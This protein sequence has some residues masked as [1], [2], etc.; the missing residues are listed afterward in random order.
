M[1]EDNQQLIVTGNILHVARIDAAGVVGPW[2]DVGTITVMNP[3]VAATSIS[4]F[5]SRGGKRLRIASRVTEYAET[6]GD[7]SCSN[8]SIDNLA[9]TFG[10]DAII[11]YT[12]AATPLVDVVHRAFPDSI[13]PLTDNSGNFLYDVA[14]VQTISTQAIPATPLV[15]GVHYDANPNFLR[16]GYVKMLPAAP[17]AA[18]GENVLVDFTPNAIAGRRVFNPHTAG[19]AKVEARIFWTSDDY[20]TLQVR[21][22]FQAEITPA[23]PEFRDTDFSNMK[24]NIAVLS[25]QKVAGRPAGRFIMPVSE[26]GLPNR[27]Y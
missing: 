14:S 18:G 13:L 2:R 3:A 12:Q 25:T 19:V 11:E 26:G 17:L 10:A 20:K 24:F 8:M 23:N 21:D 9:F 1:R 4:L 5:D 16:M 22:H 6:Y 27:T 15:A 7:V